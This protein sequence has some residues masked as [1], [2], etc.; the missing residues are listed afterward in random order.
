MWGAGG[1]RPA[2]G[3]GPLGRRA[4]PVCHAAAVIVLVE[5]VQHVLEVRR[6]GQGVGDACSPR[7]GRAVAGCP[8]FQ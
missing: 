7:G 8:L 4:P 5:C 6:A 1:L 3:P 2:G